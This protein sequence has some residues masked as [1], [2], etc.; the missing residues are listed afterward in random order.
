M[1]NAEVIFF[2]TFQSLDNQ[3]IY[4]GCNTLKIDYSRLT[5]LN[6]KYNNDKSRDFTRPDLPTGDGMDNGMPMGGGGKYHCY[7]NLTYK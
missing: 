6:L 7:I 2:L 5:N 1:T 3:N 4:N